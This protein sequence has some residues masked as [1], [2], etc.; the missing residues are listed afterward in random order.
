MVTKSFLNRIDLAIL[1]L[2]ECALLLVAYQAYAIGD[3]RFSYVFIAMFIAAVPVIL[4]FV[5]RVTLPFGV[6]SLIGLSLF[7][8]I[9]GGVMRWYWSPAFPLFDKMA[10]FVSG[11]TVGMIIFVFFIMLDAWGIRFRRYTVLLGIFLIMA[12]FGGLWK[13]SEISL[14]VINHTIFN[15]G[16]SDLTGDFICHT[17]GSVFAALVAYIYMVRMPR[18]EGL[19]YLIRKVK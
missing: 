19:A 4:E 1:A 8:H 12:I 11:L 15:D 9:G 13:V 14:D 2:F 5:F 16:L 7:L 6:K 3:Y 10:H 18:D 17:A